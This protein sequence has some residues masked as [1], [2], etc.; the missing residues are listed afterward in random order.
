LR[1][2]RDDLGIL[3]AALLKKIAADRASNLK[4]APE[5]ARALF[6]YDWP[7]NIRELEQCLKACV[8]LA[9]GDRIELIHLPPK[10]AKVLDGAP[11][12]SIVPPN[13][14]R[15]EQ[16]RLELLAELARHQGNLTEVGRAMGKTRLQVHRWCKRFGIDPE[17]Y[18]LKSF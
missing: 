18:R 4:M 14:E 16:L 8:A 9:Q 17:L 1:D 15:S 11:A 10:V 12:A 3:I 2:R 13:K 6:L 7:H 5:V